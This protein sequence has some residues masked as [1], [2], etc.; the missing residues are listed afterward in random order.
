MRSGWG[1][2]LDVPGA[3]TTDGVQLVI[4]TCQGGANQRWFLR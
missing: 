1:K 4:W 2:C 3:S